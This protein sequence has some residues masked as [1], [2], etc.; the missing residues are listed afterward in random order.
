MNWLVKNIIH[1]LDFW[2]EEGTSEPSSLDEVES[3]HGPPS[4]APVLAAQSRKELT[5]SLEK[6]Q[7]GTGATTMGV[8]KMKHKWNKDAAK[9]TYP[10]K[11]FVFAPNKSG[12]I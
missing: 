4:K 9:Q 3:S 2:L 5:F 6:P 1:K 12:E 7:E 8:G 10:R 11:E